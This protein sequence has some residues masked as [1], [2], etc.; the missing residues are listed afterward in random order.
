[1]ATVN[2]M[3]F[4]D[5]AA[6]LTSMV[7]QVTGKSILTPTN[8]EEFVSVGQMALASGYDPITNAISQVLNRTIF[9]IRP[10]TAKFRGIEMDSQQ[11]GAWERK[12]QMSDT[13]FETDP[14]FDLPADGSSVDMYTVKRPKPL[15]LVFLGANTY[16]LQSPTYF[17]TQLDNAFRGPDELA[18]FWAMVTQTS[19]DQIEQAKETLC[20]YLL[21][22]MIAGKAVG[23]SNNVIHLLTEYNTLTGLSLTASTVY[24]PENYKAFIQW[25]FSRIAGISSMM[26]ERSQKYHVNITNHTINRHTPYSDQRVYL[27][28]PYRYQ[29][30]TMAI[31]DTFH[32]NFLRY[33][34][35]ES[36]NFWQSI[37]SPDA[38]NVTPTYLA[39][40][41]KL[42]TPKDPVALQN[43]AGIIFDRDALGYTIINESTLATP[44]NAKGQYYNMFHHFVA[45]YYNDFTENAVVLMLD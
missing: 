35:N 39:N 31:A 14:S 36:V 3:T 4:N 26:T 32:D 12:L 16:E 8:T 13:D 40:T 2:D 9:S 21:C 17:L 23:D 30:E 37:E 1:M 43:V 7:S 6:L 11:W 25:V 29:S 45:R 41:G 33:A 15:E 42:V 22:N 34:D 28:A 5:V 18:S 38:I 20:R 27:F 19:S 44:I 10:Y 24:Q